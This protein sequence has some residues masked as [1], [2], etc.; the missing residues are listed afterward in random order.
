[1]GDT[2]FSPV[3]VLVDL[4][5]KSGSTTKLHDPFV[6][7]WEERSCNVESDLD[8]ILNANSDLIIIHKFFRI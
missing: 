2:R 7:Y 3:E 4:I 6:S 8:L 5:E 1:M